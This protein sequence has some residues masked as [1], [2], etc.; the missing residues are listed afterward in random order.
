MDTH[1]R[2]E[3]QPPAR[4]AVMLGAFLGIALAAG[5]IG[6][7]VQGD[8][9]GG[10][11]LRLDRPTWAPPEWLFGVVWPVLYVLIG[12]AAW[13]LWRQAGPIGA[14]RFPL[15]LWGAQLLVNAIWPGVFFGLEAYWAAVPVIVVLVILVATT[16]VAFSRWSTLAAALLVPYLLWISYATALNVAIAV[17][18]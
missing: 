4:Q 7:L 13:W 16:I 18:N 15:G 6:N 1:E 12:V 5:L 14:L 9:V 3:R 8:D 17:A 2:H 11:Y 10:R